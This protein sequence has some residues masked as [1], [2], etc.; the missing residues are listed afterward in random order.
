[1]TREEF[2]TLGLTLT[3][4][5]TAEVLRIGRTAAYDAVRRGEIPSIPVGR[6]LRIPRHKLAAML[7]LDQQSA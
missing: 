6:S 3:V 7:G 1:V 2:E 5:E 4:E